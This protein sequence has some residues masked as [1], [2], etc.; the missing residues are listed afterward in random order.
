MFYE[1]NVRLTR[2]NRTTKP[3]PKVATIHDKLQGKVNY[4][5]LVERL[6]K[7]MEI[8]KDQAKKRTTMQ[9]KEEAKLML[10]GGKTKVTEANVEEF[11]ARFQQQ[12]LHSAAVKH[13]QLTKKYAPPLHK[14]NPM[15]KTQLKVS[16]DRLY[17]QAREKSAEA[18]SSAR[19]RYVDDVA[20]KAAKLT[21]EEV[22]EM[23]QR[24]TSRE[25]RT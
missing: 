22:A 25:P 11:I 18:H 9:A 15:S 17:Y 20:P 10:Y 23:A 16:T 21:S 8:R 6:W 1:L 19:K 3:L 14:P 2:P 24:L 7:D 12:P 13:E 4:D 5:T